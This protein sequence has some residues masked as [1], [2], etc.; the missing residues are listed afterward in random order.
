MVRIIAEPGST[1]EGAAGTFVALISLAAR[2][3]CDIFKNQWVSDPG[4]LCE[5]RRAPEY[6]EAYAKI[7]YDP[8]LHGLLAAETRGRGMLYACSVY[9]PIDV[10]VVE[11]HCDYLKCSSFESGDSAMRDAFWPYRHKT[12][13][14]F[15]MG[16]DPRGY[17]EFAARLHCVSAYPTP[18]DQMNL[19]VI[20]K[21]LDGLSDH[22]KHPWTGALAVAAGARFVEF[23]VRLD[24]ADPANADYA[25][26]R[27][28]AEAQE[29]V[30]NIRLT[31][32]MLGDGVKSIQPSERAMLQYLAKP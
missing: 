24:E 10:A 26:A 30:A 20:A 3:G 31:E 29:Y 13:V 17:E 21:G 12:I 6:R 7:A 32:R 16:G 8:N 2:I 18:E 1:A 4:Q 19:G 22:S 25:V 23:H 9:L 5:R 15:G 14:S 11:P 28:P 27:T